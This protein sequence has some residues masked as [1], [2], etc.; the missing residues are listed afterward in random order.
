MET[1]K[2]TSNGGTLLTILSLLFS[3][4]AFSQEK[5]KFLNEKPEDLIVS[6]YIIGGVAIFGVIIFVISKIA[7]KYS[8]E[9]DSAPKITRSV[10]HRHHHHHKVVKKSA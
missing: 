2:K 5:S 7:A 3:S 8:K 10:S 9:D 4:L 6:G 1:T